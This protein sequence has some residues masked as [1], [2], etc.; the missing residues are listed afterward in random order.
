MKYRYPIIAC[1]LFFLA[2]YAARAQ[3][4]GPA[5][6]VVTLYW[7]ASVPNGV[8]YVYEIQQSLSITNQVWTTIA[9]NVPSSVLSLS[10][11]VDRD[12]KYFRMRTVNATNSQWV[13]D[14]SNV[15]NTSWPPVGGN[16]GIRQ[17]P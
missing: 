7:T 12:M 3:A 11:N 16:F 2:G 5:T 6:N 10:L 9:A 1:V 8:P 17:G 14:F 13:G 15:A 4:A